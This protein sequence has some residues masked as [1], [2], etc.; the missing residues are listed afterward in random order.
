MTP[1]PIAL[2]VDDDC[3]ILEGLRLAHSRR[4]DVRL[5]SSGKAG[6]EVLASEP[7]IAIIVSDFAMPIM[8]GATFL[9]RA[10]VAAPNAVRLLLTGTSDIESAARAVNEGRIFHFLAKPC[11]PAA[12][13][14]AID[15]ALELHR[16]LIAKASPGIS[17]SSA[18]SDSRESLKAMDLEEL[19][20]REQ[21]VLQ[22]IAKGLRITDVAPL[23]NITPHTVCS[24][25]KS[26][27]RKRQLGSRAEAALEA[28]RLGLA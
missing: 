10:C 4:F 7:D 3:S 23:L 19:T 16:D 20:P 6:L 1:K 27:Y 28:R 11:S 24:H 14:S 13:E 17:T 21:E 26:I 12:L 8:D 5:A 18:T 2:F 9:A 22:L 25:I 15:L